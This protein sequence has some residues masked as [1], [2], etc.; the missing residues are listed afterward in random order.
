MSLVTGGLGGLGLIASYH[1]AAYYGKPVITTSRSGRPTTPGHMT[2]ALMEALNE[3]CVHYSVKCDAGNA[4][5]LHDMM[6]CLAKSAL[7]PSQAQATVRDLIGQVQ[8]K[9]AGMSPDKARS[10]QDLVEAIKDYIY[11]LLSEMK[12]RENTKIDGDLVEDL[13]ETL[14]QAQTCIYTLSAASGQPASARTFE[15]SVATEE[16]CKVLLRAMRDFAV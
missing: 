14:A 10:L 13:R 9:A 11:A 2:D 15:W 6:D 5:E 7:P 3:K 1:S 4:Q 8:R 12:A 16:R